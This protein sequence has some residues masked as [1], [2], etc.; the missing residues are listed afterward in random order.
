MWPR[1]INILLGLWLIL[2]PI[3][4]GAEKT[5]ANNH[6]VI[7]PVIVSFSFIAIWEATRVV[8]LYNLPLGAWLLLAPWVLGYESTLAIVNDMLI[9]ALVICF[10]LIRGKIEQRF[11]G[12][13]SAIWKS[14]SLHM[15]EA[16]KRGHNALKQQ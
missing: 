3:V 6:Y 14:D 2:S 12:G 10:S 8:R 11:G 13:W 5:V 1:I 4:L 16:R 9:G 7:G 15:Q